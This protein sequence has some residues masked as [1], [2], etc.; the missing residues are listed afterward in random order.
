LVKTINEHMLVLLT[1]LNLPQHR[2]G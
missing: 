1:N 2:R